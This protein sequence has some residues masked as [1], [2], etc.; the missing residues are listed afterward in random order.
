MTIRFRRLILCLVLILTA[1]AL[2]RPPIRRAEAKAKPTL[3][4]RP[5]VEWRVYDRAHPRA[6]VATRG[7]V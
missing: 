6:P 5:A 3:Q 1:L 4:V 2:Y 7:R